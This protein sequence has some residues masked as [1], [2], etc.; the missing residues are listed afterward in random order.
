MQTLAG[1]DLEGHK[2]EGLSVSKYAII[3]QILKKYPDLTLDEL[4]DKPTK[5]LKALLENG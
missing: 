2:A 1:V 3:S 5:E 4:R